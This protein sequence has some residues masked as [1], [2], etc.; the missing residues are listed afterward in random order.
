MQEYIE[1]GK[2]NA[3]ID[4]DNIILHLSK[5]ELD[6]FIEGKYQGYF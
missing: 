6:E 4:N 5:S 2:L 1:A 3:S